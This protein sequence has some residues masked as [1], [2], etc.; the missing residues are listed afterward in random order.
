LDQITDILKNATNTTAQGR[1]NAINQ[2]S[3]LAN[4]AMDYAIEKMK[5]ASQERLAK[6]NAGNKSTEGTGSGGGSGNSSGS[7][8]DTDTD[9]DVEGG[10]FDSDDEIETDDEDIGDGFDSDDDTDGDSTEENPKSDLLN[11][12]LESAIQAIQSGKSPE[13]FFANI[14][15][16]SADSTEIQNIADNFCSEMGSDLDSVL[17][18]ILT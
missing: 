7:G 18:A 10:S 15:N 1:D 6:I 3:T 12:V 5:T 4:K 17:D 2:S 13:E 8:D 9:E 16:S 14:T 11:T